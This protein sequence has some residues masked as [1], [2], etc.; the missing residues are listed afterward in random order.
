[1]AP[2][3]LPDGSALAGAGTVVGMGIESA[4]GVGTMA[5]TRAQTMLQSMTRSMSGA[6]EGIGTALRNMGGQAAMFAP[7]A[8]GHLPEVG[9]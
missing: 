2:G 3:P 6:L 8:L 9:F 1:M 7:E 4:T 5:L